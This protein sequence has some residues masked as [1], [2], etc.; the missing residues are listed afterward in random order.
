MTALNGGILD[1]RALVYRIPAVW[2]LVYQR[3]GIWYTNDLGSGMP[4]PC[5]VYEPP[6]RVYEPRPPSAF[7]SPIRVYEP[8]YDPSAFMNFGLELPIPV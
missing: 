3:F 4:D 2:Y 7:M 6:I 5:R 1:A 8:L